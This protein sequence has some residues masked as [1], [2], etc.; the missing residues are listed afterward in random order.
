[1]TDQIIFY[2]DSA[3]AWEKALYAFLG[4]KQERSGSRR[5][6]E[7]SLAGEAAIIVRGDCRHR[8]RR[9]RD[10]AGTAGLAERL[11]ARAATR[12][13]ADAVASVRRKP[14]T[15]SPPP[16]GVGRTGAGVGCTQAGTP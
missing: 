8:D 9:R 16:V 11:G 1:M 12:I 10:D 2:N 15:R 3:T 5:T 14:R 4:E 6:V 13:F 7:R